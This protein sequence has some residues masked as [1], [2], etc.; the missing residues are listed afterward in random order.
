MDVKPTWTATTNI[1]SGHYGWYYGVLNKAKRNQS[2]SGSQKKRNR[3]FSRVRA[4]VQNPLPEYT[5]IAFTVSEDDFESVTQNIIE[6]G[7][8]RWQNNR[9]EGKSFYFLD[10]D[11]HKL[12]I[13]SGDWK[14]RLEGCKKH[15]YTDMEFF[16]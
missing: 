14:S 11:G 16:D 1:R 12:E 10:P 9:S 13:H 3:K 6:S 8:T 4:A 7:A 2:Q 5:H 15:P